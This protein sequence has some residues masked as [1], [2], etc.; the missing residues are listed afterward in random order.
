MLAL[1]ATGGVN[2]HPSNWA[3]FIVVEKAAVDGAP[4]NA[5]D[6]PTVA[7]VLAQLPSQAETI[8]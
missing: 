8:T 4:A 3:P 2:A 5:L 6:W 7:S 1:T